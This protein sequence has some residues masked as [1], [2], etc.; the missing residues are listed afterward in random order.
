MKKLLCFL[1][2]LSLLCSVLV[3][4][5]Q[6]A[7]QDDPLKLI[8]ASDLHWRKDSE[9]HSQ[10]FFHPRESLGQVSAISPL[11]VDRFLQ[12]AAASDADFLLLTGDLT[13]MGNVQDST[14]FAAVLASFEAQTGKQIFVINGN[15]DLDMQD[16]VPSYSMD[17]VQFREIYHQF[18]YDE[19]LAVDE[20]TSSYAVDLKNGYRLLALNSNEWNGNGSGAISDAL[21]EWV[22][23]QVETAQNRKPAIDVPDYPRRRTAK[24]SSS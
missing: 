1:L 8:V 5:T 16:D 6:A 13:D 2:A 3:F 14:A 11:I 19:A 7:S 23:S 10:R 12:D 24:K 18:G 20:A 4:G 17:H 15:H 21:L 9:V 22:T